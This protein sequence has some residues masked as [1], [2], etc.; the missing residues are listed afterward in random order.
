MCFGESL[1]FINLFRFSFADHH[2]AVVERDSGVMRK[3]HR[4]SLRNVPEYCRCIGMYTGQM[5]DDVNAARHIRLGF[6]II[7]DTELLVAVQS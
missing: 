6:H 5:L 2:V 7:L 3:C 1:N 4:V